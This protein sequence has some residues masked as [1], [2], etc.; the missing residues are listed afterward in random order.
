MRM[1]QRIDGNA[2]SEIQIPIAVGR[3]KPCALASLEREVD[4][5]ICRQ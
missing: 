1:T 5:R 3:E 4:A 2:G